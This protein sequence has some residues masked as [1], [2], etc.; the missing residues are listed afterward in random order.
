MVEV[1]HYYRHDEFKGVELTHQSL[2]YLPD[3][4][5]LRGQYG[6]K[7]K[8]FQVFPLWEGD[9]ASLRVDQPT[10]NLSH[11]GPLDLACHHIFDADGVL[12]FDGQVRKKPFEGPDR[13]VEDLALLVCPLLHS[14]NHVIHLAIDVGEAIQG[15]GWARAGIGYHIN[16]PVYHHWEQLVH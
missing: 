12:G 1:C 8:D 15:V 6:E 14:C 4:T 7:L 9:R 5:A 13:A 16:D 11:A 2:Q 3:Y 10:Q